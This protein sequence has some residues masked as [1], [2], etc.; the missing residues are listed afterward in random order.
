MLIPEIQLNFLNSDFFE[1][2]MNSHADAN[3]GV[4]GGSSHFSLDGV[5]SIAIT[6]C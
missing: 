4:I 1:A 2:G 5:V 3:L 6:K